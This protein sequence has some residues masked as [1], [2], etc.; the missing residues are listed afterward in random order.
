MLISRQLLNFKKLKP[1]KAYFEKE[2][3]AILAFLFGSH[4]R[5]L[6]ME[7]SDFDIAVFLKDKGSGR[8]GLDVAGIVEKEVDLVRLNEAPATL[9]SNVIKTGIPL[10]IKDRKLYWD[11][12]LKASME[13]EDFLG[14]MEDFWRIYKRSKSL[15]PED[16]KT[17]GIRRN[18]KYP[19]P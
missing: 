4:S 8:I 10:A 17:R 11:L 15:I 13:S 2:P 7:G 1:L 14:F 5:G 6:E 19:C 18:K 3:S 9:I 12:Y 16:K